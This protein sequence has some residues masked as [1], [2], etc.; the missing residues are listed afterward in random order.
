MKIGD[1]VRDKST[2]MEGS[3]VGVERGFFMIKERTTGKSYTYNAAA[4]FAFLQRRP[5][6]KEAI[7]SM[8]KI[9]RS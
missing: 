8:A 6:L 4:V 5:T 3:L 2:G 9:F 1:L 7:E